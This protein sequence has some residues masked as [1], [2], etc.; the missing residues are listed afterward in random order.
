MIFKTVCFYDLFLD[1]LLAIRPELIQGISEPI[2]KNV[3]DRLQ[4][5]H[6]MSGREAEE[7]S[8]RTNVVQDQVAALIDMVLK[9][10]QRACDMFLSLLR[11]CDAYFYK[12]L[13]LQDLVLVS[14]V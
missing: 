8:Q 2:M 10:G 3:L 5:H 7:I 1:R 4:A 9:K 12:D 13:G 6:V 14:E 11:K